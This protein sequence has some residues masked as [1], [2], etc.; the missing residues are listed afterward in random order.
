MFDLSN[1]SMLGCTISKG[2][3]LIARHKKAVEEC[4]VMVLE[5]GGNDSDHNWAEISES[6]ETAH[7]PKTPIDE[8]CKSYKAIIDELSCLGKNILMLNLP[9]IDPHKYLNWFSRGLDK[10]KILEWL[11]GSDEYIYKFHENYNTQVCRIAEEN[12]I[13]LVDI[14]SAFLDK[15]NYS[16]YLCDDGIHPNE[17]GHDLIASVISSAI[18][19]LEQT[20]LERAALRMG[21]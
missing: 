13:P 16:D 6:P 7:L 10:A 14:R 12:N 20:L 21:A 3:S 8:F 2:R 9:P 5:Y 15:P 1:Y 4:D 19:Q 18:P 11:G 17:R